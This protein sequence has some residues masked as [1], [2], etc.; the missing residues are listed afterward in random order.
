MAKKVWMFFFAFIL[1]RTLYI[2][3][4]QCFEGNTSAHNF[5]PLAH[6]RMIL[7]TDLFNN[8]TLIKKH[9]H[10]LKHIENCC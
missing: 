9:W 10:M 6:A 2:P 3:T 7:A 5:E 8:K 1:S 4:G